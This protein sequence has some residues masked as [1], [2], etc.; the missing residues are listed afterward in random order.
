MVVL[1]F[2][3]LTLGV[4]SSIVQS[5]ILMIVVLYLI[6]YRFFLPKI[7]ARHEQ[8]ALELDV[9][10]ISTLV[11]VFV[12]S[13]GGILSEFFFLYYFLSIGIALLLNSRDSILTIV[14]LIFCY[15]TTLN[16]SDPYDLL[17]AVLRLFSLLLTVPITSF[18]AYSYLKN[19]E[20]QHNIYILVDEKK[21][22]KSI[23][24]QIQHDLIAW[25]SF[26]VKGPLANIKGFISSVMDEDKRINNLTAKQKLYLERA[27]KSNEHAIGL[28]HELDAKLSDQKYKGETTDIN[29]PEQSVAMADMQPIAI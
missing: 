12:N 18:F 11:I 5:V 28:L 8:L 9:L 22:Y 7:I 3:P 1:A 26:K 20:Q 16:G 24:E 15:V 4:G 27:Y 10:F 23:I 29:V 19:Q 2:T 6:T 21:K 14:T 17:N 13:M 25:S